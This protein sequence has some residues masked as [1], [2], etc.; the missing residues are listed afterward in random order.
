MYDNGC[1]FAIIRLRSFENSDGNLYITLAALAWM[2]STL[3]NNAGEQFP[4]MA[5]QYVTHGMT[6]IYICSFTFLGRYLVLFMASTFL[7]K[8]LQACAA[9]AYH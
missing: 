5:L 4:Q 1:Q 8:F 7:E 3:S 2:F 9:C 6:V